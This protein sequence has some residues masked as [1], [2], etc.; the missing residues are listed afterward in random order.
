MNTIHYR[1]A[2]GW[3]ESTVP[4]ETTRL[5]ST[6][7]GPYFMPARYTG[8]DSRPD[9]TVVRF[10]SNDVRAWQYTTAEADIPDV[11]RGMTGA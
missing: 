3:T 8:R 6:W 7:D 10:E 2:D 9:T 4:D 11:I 1:P 5:F